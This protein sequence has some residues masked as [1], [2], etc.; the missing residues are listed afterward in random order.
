M[1]R[2]IVAGVL[3]F[4]SAGALPA[5]QPARV[6]P[7][8]RAELM[9]MHDSL[10]SAFKGKDA[11]A[12]ARFYADDARMDGERGQVVQGRAAIDRFWAGVANPKSWKLEVITVG[13]GADQPYEIGRSTITTSGPNGN[14]VSAVE[15]LLLWRRDGR[16]R[17][18]I[19]VDYYRY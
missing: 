1:R 19:I 2:A 13:G 9:A 8:L 16:G 3:A 10:I 18:R 15:Y 4:L 6:R 12:V 5:Q 14:R 7:A 17:L 11:A